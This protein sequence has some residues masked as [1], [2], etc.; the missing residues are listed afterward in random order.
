MIAC[1]LNFGRFLYYVLTKFTKIF[2]PPPRFWSPLLKGQPPPADQKFPSPTPLTENLRKSPASPCSQGG[3][4][5]AATV[6]I[7]KRC[8]STFNLLF[9]LSEI[10]N[11]V[12]VLVQ[13][14]QFFL[15]C[16]ADSHNAPPWAH[17]PKLVTLVP[18]IGL[19]LVVTYWHFFKISFYR[20]S[21]LIIYLVST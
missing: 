4:H 16:M 3:R 12:L 19:V 2:S 6:D 10:L 21:I 1:L 11:Q 20:I 5:Y 14:A 15:Q 17:A 7:L 8:I 18:G 13:I 9:K